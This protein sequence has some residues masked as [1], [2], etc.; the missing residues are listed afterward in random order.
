[1]R[2]ANLLLVSAAFFI[3]HLCSYTY[4][5]AV[6]SS[7]SE[8]AE[9][10][11][12]AVVNISTT[13]IVKETVRSFPFF[14]GMPENQPEEKEM[15]RQSLGSGFIIDSNGFILTC[16][17]VIQGAKDIKV[18]L[19]NESEFAG[20]IAGTDEKTDIAL[21]RIHADGPLPFVTMGDANK[22]KVGDWVVAVGNPFGLG[23]TVTAGIVSAKG[24][25][26]GSGP[27][28]DYIQT[29]AAINPGNSGGP[30]FNMNGEVIGIN[31]AIFST[32][33]G[34][35]GIGFAIPI[36]IAESII[37]SLK[38]V[39]YVERGWL[40][41]TVQKITPNLAKSFSLSETNG[42]LVADVVKGSPAEEAGIRRGDIITAYE[43]K[44]LKNVNELPRL[45]AAAK[46]GQKASITV[47]RDGKP[48]D[49]SVKIGKMAGEEASPEDLIEKKI[50]IKTRTI[51]PEIANQ[52]GI[53]DGGAVLVSS[54]TEP[55]EKGGFVQGDIILEMNRKRITN[56]EELAAALGGIKDGE[57]VLFLV[58][59]AQGFQ[60][61]TVEVK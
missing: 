10:N 5:S 61:I 57:S 18:T 26:I 31:S 11:S 24:R 17:H 2:R 40:G 4:A 21:I 12:N 30:L 47:I 33:G 23:H 38:S 52:L 16:S 36:N 42:A 48:I 37:P 49:L 7:F 53:M 55:A 15:R 60:Y 43:G 44:K 20:D 39:G 34:N 59:R 29:D 58:R 13:Q 14:P 27:Y 46:I 51:T 54:L 6:P 28:D 1:M 50:G 35:I 45:V 56:T 25:V 22:L 41:V 8:I 3:L 9:K 32:S 19:W